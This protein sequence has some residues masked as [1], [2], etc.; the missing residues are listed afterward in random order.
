MFLCAG[1]LTVRPFSDLLIILQPLQS[2][3]LAQ[4]R[5][6]EQEQ[7]ARVEAAAVDAKAGP[8]P[9]LPAPVANFGALGSASNLALARHFHMQAQMQAQQLGPAGLIIQQQQQTQLPKPAHVLNMGP[10]LDP[11]IMAAMATHPEAYQQLLNS[12]LAQQGR[13][14]GYSSAMLPGATSTILPSQPSAVFNPYGL[15]SMANPAAQYPQE[16]GS[17]PMDVRHWLAAQN[18][19]AVIAPTMQEHMPDM[20]MMPQAPAVLHD[21][22]AMPSVHHSSSHKMPPDQQS[23][24][25][26]K[27]DWPTGSIPDIHNMGL[28]PGFHC[29][30]EFLAAQAQFMGRAGAFQPDNLENQQLPFGGEQRYVYPL[31]CVLYEL[32]GCVLWQQHANT[33][34]VMWVS[35]FGNLLQAT[36][37]SVFNT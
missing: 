6:A 37:C 2:I 32:C 24:P 35:P 3:N 34:F 13:T 19:A 15:A 4:E 18:A 9:S 14:A 10:A 11:S 29:Q 21:S 25:S 23:V 20:R 33:S 26:S 12:M 17:M 7:Q 36:Q 1:T 28:A 22:Q 30:A 27:W 16:I 8:A 5:S 31:C